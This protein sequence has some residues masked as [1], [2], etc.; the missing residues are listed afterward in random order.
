[1]AIKKPVSEGKENDVVIPQSNHNP[2]MDSV[3]EKTYS[4][5]NVN[6]SQEQISNAINEPL[7]QAQ[8]IDTGYNPYDYLNG[9]TQNPDNSKN[10][11]SINPAMQD[12]S[13]Q[14]KKMGAEYMAKIIIDA[15]E[16]GH[17]LANTQLVFNEK[18][19][20]KLEKE[21]EINLSVEIPYEY[22]KTIP[23]GEFIKEFNEQNKDTLVV[24]KEFKKEVTPVLTRVLEKKGAGLTDEQ[25][26]MYAF[27]KDIA[28]KGIMVFQMKN[29]MND[30]INMM[31]DFTVNGQPSQ[32]TPPPTPR[33]NVKNK[34]EPVYENTNVNYDNPSFNFTQNDT[35]A[36]TIVKKMEVP[37]T[38]KE[39]L[40]K[41]KAKEKNWEKQTNNSYSEAIKSRSKVDNDNNPKRGRPKKN[42]DNTNIADAIV[43]KEMP[44]KGL[45]KIEG[46][47]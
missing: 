35:V 21:G 28:V 16:Q 12:F 23:A 19:L 10:Q 7:Y 39:R 2:F 11:N 20:A 9:E 3:N 24:T 38:G 25:F 40:M 47:D 26:L 36:D 18:K 15:Y 44:D 4:Q 5:I 27:G 32:P 29:T 42:Y 6:A 41:Q 43:I 45:D 31:K 34:K 8:Q 17:V 13:D 37:K 33:D 46:L 1:M 22:G 30:M 14:D